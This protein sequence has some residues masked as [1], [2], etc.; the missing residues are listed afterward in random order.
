MVG[1]RGEA[2]VEVGSERLPI[3]LTNRALAEVEKATGR[4]MIEIAQGVRSGS[5]GIGE[6]AELLRAGL[7]YGRRDA[8]NE[9]R[10][11]S[12]DDAW[13]ILDQV[14]FV[15]VVTLVVTALAEVLSY[16]AR[17]E[18]DTEGPPL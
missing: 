11:Y 5:V 1:A 12:L 16:R 9:G 8:G 14:G 2:Y 10:P 4:T 7:E 3:L 13:R 17:D 18:E 15:P 6:T